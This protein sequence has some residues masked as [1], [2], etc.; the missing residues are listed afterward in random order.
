MVGTAGDVANVLELIQTD[1]SGFDL[2]FRVWEE[3]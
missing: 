2:D 1:R 3:A